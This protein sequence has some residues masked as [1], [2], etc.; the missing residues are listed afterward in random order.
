MQDFLIGTGLMT[1]IAFS[2]FF[3]L[4]V[5]NSPFF[6]LIGKIL[7]PLISSRRKRTGVGGTA[8]GVDR[9]EMLEPSYST[10]LAAAAFVSLRT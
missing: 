3:L 7:V 4:F 9:I 10:A 2:Q 8:D 5:L 6:T 1:W